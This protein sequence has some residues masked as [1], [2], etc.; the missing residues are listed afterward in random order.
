MNK[1]EL[2]K[3]IKEDCLYTSAALFK[4]IDQLDEPKPQLT[5]EW[6]NS[7]LTDGHN[8]SMGEKVIYVEDLEDFLKGRDGH[9]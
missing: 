9:E 3:R 8:V 5:N 2:K 7:H 1:E 4:L 6:I